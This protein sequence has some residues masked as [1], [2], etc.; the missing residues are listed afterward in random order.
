MKMYQRMIDAFDPD[1][2]LQAKESINLLLSLLKKGL[3]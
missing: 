3:Y 2:V 1:Y